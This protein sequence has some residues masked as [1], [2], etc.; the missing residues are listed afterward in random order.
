VKVRWKYISEG[1]LLPLYI[2]ED[3]EVGDKGEVRQQKVR[4][5]KHISIARRREKGPR[6]SIVLLID[7]A[8]PF[9]HST[10]GR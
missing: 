7:V 4:I 9:F 1:I 6:H 2:P 3:R 10:S 8:W 5:G